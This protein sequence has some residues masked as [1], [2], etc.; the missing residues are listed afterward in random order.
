MLYPSETY[1][2]KKGKKKI[3]MRGLRSGCRG[4]PLKIRALLE[5]LDAT[6]LGNEVFAGLGKN[7]KDTER[8]REKMAT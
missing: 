2:A 1:F 4:L 8:H 3:W 7:G 5:P 6:R